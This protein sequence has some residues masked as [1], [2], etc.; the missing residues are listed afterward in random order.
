MEEGGEGETSEVREAALEEGE[1]EVE[2]VNLVTGVRAAEATT[3]L[4]G[5]AE[6][7]LVA[8][9]GDLHQMATSEECL[10]AAWE[11]GEETRVGA[12]VAVAEEGGD[13]QVHVK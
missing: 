5:E 9:G 13:S 1:E 11:A 8:V 6:E 2:E 10:G 3:A 7:D 12:M 4:T